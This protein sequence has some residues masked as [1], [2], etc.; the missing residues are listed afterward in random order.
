MSGVEFVGLVLG[1]TSLVISALEQYQSILSNNVQDYGYIRGLALETVF[2]QARG[3]VERIRKHVINHS[4]DDAKEAWAVRESYT[5]SFNMIAV[6][7]SPLMLLDYLYHADYRVQGA[8]VAQIAITALSLEYLEATH[9]T[10]TAAFV[11]SLIAG[12]LSVY[13]ACIL[14]QQLS[15]LHGPVEAELWFTT[16]R[17]KRRSQV[18]SK[19]ETGR[20]THKE[21]IMP[22]YN[23]ALLL[24]LPSI[25]LNW[26]SIALL[27]GIGIY[28]GIVHTQHLSSVRG[29]NSSLAILLVYVLFTLGAFASYILPWLQKQLESTAPAQSALEQ[30]SRVD[31]RSAPNSTARQEASGPAQADRIG[32][33]PRFD[34]LRTGGIES[35]ENPAPRDEESVGAQDNAQLSTVSRKQ[36]ASILRPRRE[37]RPASNHA[38]VNFNAETSV[39]RS[40]SYVPAA[41]QAFMAAL[42]VSISAQ[43]AS[44]QAHE[45]LRAE[46]QKQ[47]DLRTSA[48]R[49]SM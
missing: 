28:Y 27:I 39:S 20:Q 17:R 43:K 4:G 44:L 36:S 22:S 12:L 18:D 5:T 25:L 10:A 32:R 49:T 48:R 23:A 8:I 19:I 13:Y 45:L 21:Y 15:G 26:S 24:V 30:L 6:A 40:P 37:P 31:P 7:V 29:Q 34:L 3:V 1:T 2:F 46:I 33:P 35:L 9:W 42:D 16:V 47:E 41:T 11:I 38:L 14:Q